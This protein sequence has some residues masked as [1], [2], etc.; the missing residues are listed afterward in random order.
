MVA[1]GE[2]DSADAS[3]TGGEISITPEQICSCPDS[4][5]FPCGEYQQ[6]SCSGYGSP[7]RAYIRVRAQQPFWPIAPIPGV[8][9]S[10]IE[11][12]TWMRVR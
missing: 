8:P 12:Y 5:P 10:N 9:E 6:T 1:M 4:D 11:Q 3:R 2:D 7:P